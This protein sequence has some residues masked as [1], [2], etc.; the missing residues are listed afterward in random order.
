MSSEAHRWRSRHL[1]EQ[2]IAR[3]R[4]E[5]LE[6]PGLALTKEQMRRHW[7]LDASACDT[8]VDAL[9]A[10]GFLHQRADHS[11]VRQQSDLRSS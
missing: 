8:I 7:V 1:V 10:S 9:V 11:F 5:Y 4:A 6:S 3:V 2:L